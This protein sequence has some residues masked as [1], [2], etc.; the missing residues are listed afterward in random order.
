MTDAELRP[1]RRAPYPFTQTPQWALLMTELTDR[2]FRVYTLLLAHLN[3][4]RGDNLAWPS[5]ENMGAMLGRHRNR[6]GEA[7]TGLVRHGLVDRHVVR[8]GDSNSRRRNIYVVHETP[9][10]G[11]S[12]WDGIGHWHRENQPE[13]TTLTPLESAQVDGITPGQLARPEIGATPCTDSGARRSPEISARRSTDSGAVTRRTWNKKKPNQKKQTPLTPRKRG[14]RSSRVASPG[15]ESGGAD[16]SDVRAVC[17]ALADG[18]EKAGLPRPKVTTAW[19]R[20]AARMLDEDGLSLEQITHAIDWALADAFWSSKV[21]SVA[22]LRRHYMQM[23]LTAR[24]G[25]KRQKTDGTVSSDREL[26]RKVNYATDDAQKELEATL[27]RKLEWPEARKL[28]KRVQQKIMDGE[29]L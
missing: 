5:V 19:R 25:V 2:E 12:G 23:S 21:V 27:G 9:P 7:I 8:H 26:M 22:K 13:S 17:A 6:I 14:E 11:W 3:S 20:S 24:S 16:R 10:D 18:L 29:V 28:R 15:T 1:G 4:S